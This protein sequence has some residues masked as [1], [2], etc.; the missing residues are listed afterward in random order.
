MN[1][2]VY[3]WLAWRTGDVGNAAWSARTW[4]LAV[5]LF[6]QVTLSPKS[7]VTLLGVNPAW[8]MSTDLVA[9]KAGAIART[10][11]TARVLNSSLLISKPF[12]LLAIQFDPLSGW[13]ET[14][15][16]TL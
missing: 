8:V 2:Y 11:R 6:V 1:L 9:E 12:G 5:S 4:W 3:V 13:T 7:I 16:P 15:A 14:Q 10:A